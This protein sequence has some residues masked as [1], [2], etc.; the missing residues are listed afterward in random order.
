M[1]FVSLLVMTRYVAHEYGVMVW[2]LALVSLVNTVAD[3]GFN[4][5]NLKFIAKEGYD[6]SACFSTY[7]V[8]KA[9]LTGIM[10]IGTVA[11]VA[12]MRATDIINEEAFWVCLVF[13]IYQIISNVQFAIYY[14]LDGM[15]MS[16]KSSILTIVECSIRN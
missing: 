5:A 16:G 7:M 12:V 10:I 2:G 1:A 15:M 6:R 4:S 3:L 9:A 14:T 13:V 8:I 11:T